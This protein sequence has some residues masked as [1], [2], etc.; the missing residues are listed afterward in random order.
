MLFCGFL[1]SQVLVCAQSDKGEA[2]ANPAFEQVFKKMNARM[3]S[4]FVKN[5]RERGLKELERV[6][7]TLMKDYPEALRP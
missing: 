1:F 4:S 3:R 6:A 2:Y 5:G 7:E